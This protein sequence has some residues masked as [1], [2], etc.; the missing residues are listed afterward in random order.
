MNFATAQALAN[1]VLYEGY[2]LYP[3]R[4][5][6]KKNQVRFQFGVVAPRAYAEVMGVD[7]PSGV[8]G[9]V[10]PWRT[11]TECLLEPGTDADITVVVRFLQLQARL[12]E[13]RTDD[14]FRPV[15]EL[16]LGSSR[17]VSWDEAVERNIEITLS[18]AAL[19]VGHRVE[20]FSFPAAEE[21][22]DVNDGAGRIVRRLSP[23]AGRVVLSAEE[24]PGPYGVVRLRVDVENLSDWS[25]DDPIAAR[26]VALHHS[27]L[28]AHSMIGVS[29]GRF[30]SL[31]DPPEWAGPLA[32]SCDN[33]STWPI[34]IGDD[35]VM[36]SAP[37]ILYDHQ[38]I[39]AES[40][41]DLYDGLEIDEILSL[42][43]LTL[44]DEEKAEA[45]AT[46][47]RAAAIIDRVDNMSTEV[48]SR[49]HGA[50][51]GLQPVSNGGGPIVIGTPGATATGLPDLGAFDPYAELT[52]EPVPGK[53]P[54]VPW[55]DPAADASVDPD[56]D[57]VLVQG[58]P[59][60]KGAKV[61]L[62]PGRQLDVSSDVRRVT[63]AQDLFYDGRV[64][65]VQA[66]IFD[67]DG[68]E[69]L[70]CSLEDVP[71][72]D[73]AHGRF[74]YFRPTEV[75]PTEEGQL[76]QA[77]PAP[78]IL[79]AGV[80]NIFLS[81]DGFGVEVAQRLT[82]V[83]L[84]SD[85]KVTDFGIRGMHLAYELCDGYDLA[86]L[87]DATPRGGQPGT[88][89]VIE[90]DPAPEADPDEV[91]PLDAHGMDP[92]SVLSLLGVLGGQVDKVLVVGCEP[93][94][95]DEGMGLSPPVEAAVDEAVTLVQDLIN[96][97]RVPSLD[98]RR[99]E[100]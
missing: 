13:E 100:T 48:L 2:V 69:Y 86:I 65:I 57:S 3:Y 14:G 22:E 47:P 18:V 94:V 43:T 79:V 28:S 49:L 83:D 60:S 71:D 19:T 31:L 39:A 95:A 77:L 7:G 21:I 36:L 76:H 51:R 81:D 45:R 10:E 58:V 41:G 40:P 68:D 59:V 96:E 1:T 98:G 8:S 46:D 37:I 88:L 27:L 15:A 78:R 5:S 56:T 4:A 97:H 25:A 93:A 35:D 9:A 34:L 62:R 30:I 90:P 72:V 52:R 50:L 75:D 12:V 26:D 61:V 23:L 53:D 38:E 99:R 80:G 87:V 6:A 32:K 82:G 17:V 55:W 20:A 54:S 63:D 74:L 33:R 42:R 84:G 11:R 85:V 16:D 66:V 92:E 73:L 29:R 64:A 70:A 67:V 89:Y 24:V 44:T 91:P